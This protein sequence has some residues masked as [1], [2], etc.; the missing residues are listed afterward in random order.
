MLLNDHPGDA[1]T[2]LKLVSTLMDVEL[3]RELNI[4]TGA[5]PARVDVERASFNQCG[6]QA[7]SDMRNANI[8]RT[9]MGSIAM[10]N[11]N[12]GPV[13]E[14]IYQVVHEHLLGK[15]NDEQAV[16]KLQSAMVAAQ[17]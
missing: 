6:Q 11:A 12:P 4:A 2:R 16:Q 17:H 14:A 13:K 15:I 5:A 8:R 7:I 10:G 3:Q 1:Q 9:L